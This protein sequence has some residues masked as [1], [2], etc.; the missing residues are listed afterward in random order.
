MQTAD[1]TDTSFGELFLYGEGRPCPSV[2]SYACR[3]G[4]RP[5][6]RGACAGPVQ[7]PTAERPGNRRELPHRGG[8][9]ILESVGRHDGRE[10]RIR[11]AI[12]GRREVG[13]ESTRG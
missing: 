4:R 6:R 8:R 10:R 7:T 3:A 13:R 9:R 11:S 12:G 1:P 5:R 2:R